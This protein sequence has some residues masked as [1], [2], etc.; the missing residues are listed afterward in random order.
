MYQEKV[1]PPESS[2][3]LEQGF[4]M[5]HHST[6]LDRVQEASGQCSQVHGITYRQDQELYSMILED[7]FQLNIFS[8]SIIT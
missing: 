1:L 6:R 7:A 3:A 8:N 5:S 4:Q 2:W